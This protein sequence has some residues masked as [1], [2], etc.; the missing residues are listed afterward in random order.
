MAIVSGSAALRD[1]TK[2][3]WEKSTVPENAPNAID[4]QTALQTS[5]EGELQRINR[6]LLSRQSTF[7]PALYLRGRSPLAE[8][9][10]RLLRQVS[11]SFELNLRFREIE[12]LDEMHARFWKLLGEGGRTTVTLAEYEAVI[13]AMNQE[14]EGQRPWTRQTVSETGG[15][16]EGS[17]TAADGIR[18]PPMRSPSQQNLLSYCMT[19]QRGLCSPGG[20]VDALERVRDSLHWPVH[21]DTPLSRV[22][23][24]SN[25]RLPRP[26]IELFLASPRNALRPEEVDT[27]FL[28]QV[29]AKRISLVKTEAELLMWD[30]NNDGRL[31]EDEMESYVRDLV[32]RIAALR[33]M[34]DDVLPFYC[35]TATRRI[36]WDLDQGNR[37]AIRIDALLQSAVMD[38]WVS[39]QLL[40]ED[41]PQNW[42][43]AMATRQLYEKFLLLDARNGGTLNVDNIKRYKKGLPTV[44]DD[45]LPVDVSPISTLFID[46]YFETNVM[47]AASEMDYRK[48]VDFVIAV[49]MLPQCSRPNFLWN[50]LDIE[51]SGVLTPL[52]A[53]AFF[54]ETHAKLVQA[55]LFVPSRE[56]VIQEVFD[57]IPSV[58]TL[59]ITRDEFVSSPQCGLFAA[60]LIDCLSFWAYENREQR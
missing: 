24:V 52:V 39:L 7:V 29:F 48:F 5:F 40:T 11:K 55:G 1:A 26:T 20:D 37:G 28:Y 18:S 34:T 13:A 53:N 12:S 6:E 8:D 47:M 49:E 23:Y 19:E 15:V 54:R 60:L 31:S 44:V 27:A 14:N 16:V 21:E 57:L 35:C 43:G 10:L 17:I 3:L 32:P 38:E 4:A 2:L 50:I 51:E 41:T 25:I 58:E 45:G 42:F 56:T 33:E 36:F 46:R 59:R 22:M 30:T 9:V